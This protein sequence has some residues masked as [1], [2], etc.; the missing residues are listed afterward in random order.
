MRGTGSRNSITTL[1]QSNYA[2]MIK[3][4]FG[5]RM[6]M[7]LTQRKSGGALWAPPPFV[8]KRERVLAQVVRH[9]VE[10]GVQL[11]ADALHRANGS[12]SDKSGDE[13]I[14][15]GGRTLFVA[16][17]LQK[18]AHGLRSLVPSSATAHR[19]DPAC[20]RAGMPGTYRSTS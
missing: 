8:L 19:P 14:L 17:Q 12:N 4:D 20:P 11:V 1:R 6:P 10:R 2:K 15:D 13:T 18:L 9:V 3:G 5:A 7:T 16:D